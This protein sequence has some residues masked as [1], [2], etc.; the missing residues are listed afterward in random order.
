MPGPN[1]SV[2]GRN[3]KLGV[4]SWSP[5]AMSGMGFMCDTKV[6]LSG[7]YL[8]LYGHFFTHLLGRS[9]PVSFCISLRG[10]YSVC[11]CTYSASSIGGGKFRCFLCCHFGAFVIYFMCFNPLYFLPLLKLKLSHLWPLGDSSYWLLSSFNI[12]L[13]GFDSFLAV[14]WTQRCS[15]LIMYISCSRIGNSHSYKKLWFPLV[16]N[17]ISRPYLRHRN[18]YCYWASHCF[19]SFSVKGAW[20]CMHVYDSTS[21]HTSVFNSISGL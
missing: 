3:C 9:H 19:Y 5:D 2:S 20:R 14:L 17:C 15:R 16:G 11:S 6:C 18:I 21:A 13:T 7:P 1:P 4:P 10:N 8:F 12:I